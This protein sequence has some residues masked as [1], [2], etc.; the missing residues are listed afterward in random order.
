MFRNT[1][2]MYT[3]N[4][5]INMPIKGTFVFLSKEHKDIFLETINKNKEDQC[6][7]SFEINKNTIDRSD[8]TSIDRSIDRSIDT[9]IDTQV[10]FDAMTYNNEGKYT[11]IVFNNEICKGLYEDLCLK[12]NIVHHPNQQEPSIVTLV[13]IIW[14]MSLTLNIIACYVYVVA[15]Y[16]LD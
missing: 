1:L 9:S 15:M 16:C 3:K 13:F 8:N 5:P 10:K 12:D 6:M 14:M 7:Y 2:R 4:M 11:A